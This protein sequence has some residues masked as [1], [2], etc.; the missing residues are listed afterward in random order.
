MIEDIKHDES[1]E[2]GYSAIKAC[3]GHLLEDCSIEFLREYFNLMHWLTTTSDQEIRSNTLAKIYRLKQEHN[4][5]ED[6]FKDFEALLVQY[7]CD[8]IDKLN[9]VL[10]D[11]GDDIIK[12]HH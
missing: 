11:H 2:I 12:H 7:I 1:N 5:S 4:V 6:I 10:D 3:F 9:G 8:K